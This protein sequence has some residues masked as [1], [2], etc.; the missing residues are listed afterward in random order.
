MKLSNFGGVK[1][2]SRKVGRK[3]EIQSENYSGNAH[4]H[5]QRK[6]KKKCTYLIYNFNLIS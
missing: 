5:S 4:L 1:S 3:S 2:D 6:Q